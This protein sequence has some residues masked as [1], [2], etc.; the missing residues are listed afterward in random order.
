MKYIKT[1]QHEL[2]ISF[3]E[4]LLLLPIPALSEGDGV[5]AEI[6]RGE[7]PRVAATE[8]S[9]TGLAL[10]WRERAEPVEVES[11][12]QIPVVPPAES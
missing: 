1:V 7:H 9:A 12:A 5:L 11:L 10:T 8:L 2:Q 3:E 6:L 4:L